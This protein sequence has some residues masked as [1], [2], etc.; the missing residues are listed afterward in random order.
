MIVFNPLTGLRFVPFDFRLISN[1]HR[2]GRV[3]ECV[4]CNVYRTS[5]CILSSYGRVISCSSLQVLNRS[6][7]CPSRHT[8]LGHDVVLFRRGEGSVTEQVLDAPDI[9]GITNRPE[10]RGRMPKPMQVDRKAQCL[11]RLPSDVLRRSSCH[12]WDHTG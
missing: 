3:P 11:L 1:A 5:L 7:Q 8:G 12:S 9:D 10:R 4:P 2:C 6:S